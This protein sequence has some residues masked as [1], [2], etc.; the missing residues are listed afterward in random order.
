MFRFLAVPAVAALITPTYAHANAGGFD[1]MSLLPIV[2]IFA[3]FYFLLLRPQQQKMKAHQ[4]LLSELQ[5]GD[6]VVT[7]GGIIGTVQKTTDSDA[8][9]EIADGVRVTV[10]K[11]M[12]TEVLSLPS[13]SSYDAIAKKSAP[14]KG[15]VVEIS[16][17]V[18]KKKTEDVDSSTTS[19]DSDAPTPA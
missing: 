5:R 9:V 7:A 11:Q 19:G 10:M 2:L 14:K 18:S 8:V 17:A 13:K 6:R 16:S 12:I 1:A 3:V 15:K 4:K